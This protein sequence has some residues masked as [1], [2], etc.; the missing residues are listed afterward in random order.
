MSPENQKLNVFYEE[1]KI[2]ELVR[3]SDLIYSFKYD[4]NWLKSPRKFQLSIAMPF[5]EE[6]FGNR[7]T[8]SFFE[9][10]L[11]EGEVRKVLGRNYHIESPF[12]FLKEFGKDCAGAVILSDNEKSPF[13]SSVKVEKSEIQI[14][15]NQIYKAI[16]EKQSVAEVISEMNPGYLSLAGAQDK[17]P[18]IFKDGDFYLPADGG[19]TTHI[20]KVPIQRSGVKESVYNEYYCM[21]LARAVGL[22]VPECFVDD[23]GAHPLFIIERYDRFEDKKGKIHR[24]HQ[25]DFCQAQG[26]IS[27]EKYEEKGGPTIK[28]NYQLIMKNVWIQKRTSNTFLF[29]DWICFNLLIGNNDSHSKNLSLL[30]KETRNELAPFYDL[31]CTAIYPKLK[32]QFSF[33]IG[34]RDDASHIGKNQLDSVDDLLALKKGTMVERMLLMKNNLMK[35]KDNIAKEV[36]ARHPKSKIVGRISELVENRCKSLQRQG[37]VE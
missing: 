12:E 4:Q 8:L 26:V 30:L 3:D 23:N 33:Q 20:V 16:E 27:E 37:I 28:D 36:L 14:E 10:L 13:L 18:A 7:I 17:F 25:Q 24:I 9:N 15:M 21:S 2:G 11:P 5:Q 32:R 1:L 19:P 31:L 34:D 22:N 35:H 29:L 6:S